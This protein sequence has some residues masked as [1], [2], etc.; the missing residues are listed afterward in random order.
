[1]PECGQDVLRPVD[2]IDLQIL[3]RLISPQF[4]AD[5]LEGGLVLDDHV[6]ATPVSAFLNRGKLQQEETF[7]AIPQCL[8]RRMK[9][10]N[11]MI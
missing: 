4:E 11:V 5:G 8:S 9:L 10:G 1:L 6:T 2:G 7:R 3:I